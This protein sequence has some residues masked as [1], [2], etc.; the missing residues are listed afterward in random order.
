MTRGEEGGGRGHTPHL[1][2]T[3][4]PAAES[5]QHLQEDGV[6][7]ALHGIEWLHQR[8]A[9]GPPVPEGEETAQVH[10][11]KRVLAVLKPW[12]QSK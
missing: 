9:V 5:S 12:Q 11:V 2:C 3:V 8:Q 6:S 1:A 4:E 7:V 10:Q